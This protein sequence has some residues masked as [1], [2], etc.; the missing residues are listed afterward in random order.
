MREA[1][2]A[3]DNDNCDLGEIFRSNAA[4]P[5]PEL[6]GARI[7]V[8]A[9]DRAVCDSICHW[10]MLDRFVPES[11]SSAREFESIQSSLD[12]FDLLIIDAALPDWPGFE[13]C[14]RIRE[15]HP[16][17]KL[18]VLMMTSRTRPQDAVAALSAGAN[19]SLPAPVDADE[20]QLLVRHLLMIKSSAI[21]FIRTELAFLQAQIKPHFLYNTLSSIAALSEENHTVM[22]LLLDRFGA[23][24][25][26]TLRLDNLEPLVPLRQEMQLVQSY[27]EIEK[28]R[29]ND[30][31]RTTIDIDDDVGNVLIPPLSIQSLVEN[32]VRHG[33]MTRKRGG[34]LT[35]SALNEGD[36]CQVRVQDDGIGIARAANAWHK[37]GS[38]SRGGGLTNIDRR[39]KMIYGTGLNIVSDPASGTRI[40]FIIPLAGGP[41]YESHLN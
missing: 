31:L 23:Y 29:F 22:R 14:R 27:L 19:D 32:A 5:A 24:L 4:H 16:L 26:E 8:L 3:I 20:L 40:S 2:P 37:R 13:L 38:N 28:I 36:A 30:R 15:E 34:C 39:L 21:E 41:S 11:V 17:F 9:G 7:L 1:H 18:P 35:V 33:L 6:S 12:K 10:L 25:R